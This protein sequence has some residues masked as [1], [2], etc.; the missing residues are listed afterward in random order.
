MEELIRRKYQY[1]RLIS[2]LNSCYNKLESCY[3]NLILC[4]TKLKNL[5]KIDDVYY[6]SEE[7]EAIIDK[8]HYNKN[9]IRDTVLP[10]ARRQYNNILY[11]IENYEE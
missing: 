3:T 10:S 8:M 7:F 4:R 11:A 9:V 2:N 5:L 6:N 1:E